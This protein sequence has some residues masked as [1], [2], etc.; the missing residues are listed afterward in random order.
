M[1][2]PR[3]PQ[4]PPHDGP[5]LSVVDMHT[6]GEPLRIVLSGAPAPEGRTILEKR[7]WVRENADWLR[8]VLMFEPRGHRD[9]YGALLV[10]GDE[11]EANIGVLFMHNE[12]YSTMCGHA[13]VA[14]G[15]FAV[16][17]GLVNAAQGPETAVNIQCPCGLIRAYVS[18]T[19]GRSGSVRFRSVPAF[20]FATDVTVDVP[21]YGKVVVDIAYGGAFYAFVSAETFGLDV[22][23]SRTR[24]LVDV[25]AAV[26]ES[27]KAQVKLNH[28]D[29]DDL[30]FLYGTILT[31]GKDSYSEEPT[32]NICIFAESQVDRSPTGSGVTARIALQYHKG[33]IQLEQIRTFKSGATGSLF[34]GKAV[35]ETLCGN[36][37]AVVVEVSGQ[38]YYTGASS[39]VIENKDSLKDGFLLK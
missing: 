22:C 33:L 26:T 13:I 19:G 15:R 30:A 35:K 5:M 17:Y 31:D 20:A 8:K 9:M 18:Y 4:L 36:F 25:S 37:K 2:A 6:G 34:T 1:A 14:L 16:D 7:R 29:S 24:D 32:A 11:E 10:P 21:G 38:A 28:P 23:S 12:G 3:L 39:F 27:V